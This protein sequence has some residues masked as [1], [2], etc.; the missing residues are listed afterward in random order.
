MT[1]AKPEGKPTLM[2]G[3]FQ[4]AEQ[5]RNQWCVT[6]EHGITFQQM[7]H[8]DYWAHEAR[9][10]KP[11]DLIECRSDDGTFWGLMIVLESARNWAKVH[12]LQY[13][14]LDSKDVS[15]TRSENTIT[16]ED[17]KIEYKGPTKKHVVIR[18]SDNEI[19]HEG[20]A[21]KQD[22]QAWLDDH[23]KTVA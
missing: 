6:A 14:P 21:Q 12:P 8:P 11:Y 7:L 13:V 17:Y 10:L 22:A 20:A 9:K 18:K 15:Q 16:L 1:E 3:R 2:P 5:S 19:L 23:I 4:L